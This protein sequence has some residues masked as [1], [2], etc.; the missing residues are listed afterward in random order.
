MPHPQS[1]WQPSQVGTV[2]SSRRGHTGPETGGVTD[3]PHA[4]TT[5][6]SRF[7]FALVCTMQGCYAIR[8]LRRCVLCS[9]NGPLSSY[10]VMR[11]EPG[12]ASFWMVFHSLRNWCLGRPGGKNIS[13]TLLLF[14]SPKK[15]QNENSRNTQTPLSSHSFPA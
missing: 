15:L 3:G 5:A 1:S 11:P 9:V 4:Y 13:K 12:I 7:K 6:E 8:W 2:M 14:L 10:L